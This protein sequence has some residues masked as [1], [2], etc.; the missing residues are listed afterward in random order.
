MSARIVA[1]GQC[2]LR[3]A[4]EPVPGGLAASAT[5]VRLLVGIMWLYNA[6]WKV[7]P[8]FGQADNSGLF[9]FTNYAVTH[10]VFPPFSWVVEHVVLPQFVAFGWA[11]LAVE[12]I[13]AALLLSGS[14]VRIAAT[15]GVAQSVAIGL[16][17]ARAPDEWPWSYLLMV[18]VHL[19]ILFAGAGRYLAVD[20]VRADRADG[21]GLSRFW[22]VLSAVMGLVAIVISASGSPFGPSGANLQLTGLEFGLGVYNVAGGLVLVVAGVA[23]LGWSL[24]RGWDNRRWLAWAATAI[25]AAAAVLLTAQIGFSPP[26]LG[27]DATSAAFFLTLAVVA[28]ALARESS[29][30]H[31]E[32]DRPMP[33]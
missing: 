15:L 8:D 30:R 7:P 4:I 11:V 31:H 21:L 25:S 22:G 9:V 10:P 18:A 16:S 2:L 26:V 12:T 6:A 17:V 28:A 33:G 23:I 20:A 13:L 19:L 14:F 32:T 5:L 29:P 3:S 1:G 27:G 24:A